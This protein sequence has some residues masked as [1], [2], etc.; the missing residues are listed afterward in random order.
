[1][2]I[3][4]AVMDDA[5]VLF[6]SIKALDKMFVILCVYKELIIKFEIYGYVFFLNLFYIVF[7]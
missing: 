2:F 4:D 3:D 7:V 5:L 1:M 6:I